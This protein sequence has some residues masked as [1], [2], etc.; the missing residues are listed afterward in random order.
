MPYDETL[1]AR[2]GVLL[3]AKGVAYEAKA[4]MGGLC[5]MVD[6]KM[7]VGVSNDLLMARID[8]DECERAFEQPGCRPMD[9]TGR[10][11]RG[12]VYVEPEALGTRPKLAKWIGLALD[13]NPKAK[14]S[15]KRKK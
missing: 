9:F 5:F 12:F 11:L 7:C 10:P 3:D 13:F 15:K 1:A 8:P 6:D 4:M 14:R 2:I